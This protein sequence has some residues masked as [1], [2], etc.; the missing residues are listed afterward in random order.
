LFSWA[1]SSAR[2][3]P[4]TRSALA[5]AYLEAAGKQLYAQ[6][7]AHELEGVVAKDLA[8]PYVPGVHRKLGSRLSDLGAVPE[9]RFKYSKR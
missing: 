4:L 3:E 8:S 9:E 7:L 6:A 1:I 2:L 5:V